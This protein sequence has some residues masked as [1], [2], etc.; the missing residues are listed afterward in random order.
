[1]AEYTWKKGDR[2]TAE[3]LNETGNELPAIEAG[4]AGKV[5]TVNAGET[6]AEWKTPSGGGKFGPYKLC[7]PANKTIASG[8]Q[9]SLVTGFAVDMS[10][11]PVNLPDDENRHY[12]DVVTVGLDG[13]ALAI[14]FCDSRYDFNSEMSP[15]L[16][17]INVSGSSVTLN[18]GTPFMTVLSDVEFP[19]QAEE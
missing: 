19:H 7:I 12:F 14:A 15:N 16:R 2:I 8:A 1:M 11:N 10:D 9:A 13:E 6:G 3:R 5:L 4:D 18:A 17:V